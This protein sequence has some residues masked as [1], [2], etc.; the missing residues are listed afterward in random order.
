MRFHWFHLMPYPFLPDDFKQ[1]YRSVWVDV[2][3]TLYDPEKGHWLYNQYLDQL[4]FADSLGYDGSGATSALRAQLTWKDFVEH[5]FVIAGSAATVRETLH[6]AI[7]NMRVGHLMLLLQMGD[8]PDALAR[9]NTQR[10]AQDVMPSLK[11]LWSE[12]QDHW[13]PAPWTTK[14]VTA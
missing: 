12:Y 9:E 3:S 11:G 6:H 5:G 10:F 7:T 8:L 4:E 13:Y 1:K 2:P 14:E